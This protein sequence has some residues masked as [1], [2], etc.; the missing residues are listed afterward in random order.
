MRTNS[1]TTPVQ[2]IVRWAGLMLMLAGLLIPLRAKAAA[3][4]WTALANNA[5]G[6][7]QLMILLLDGTVLCHNGGGDAWYKLTPDSSGSYINGTWTTKASMNDTRRYMSTQVLKDGRVF[8]AGGE[9]GTGGPTA[10]VYNPIANTWTLTPAAGQPDFVDSCSML[11]PNGHVLISPVNA[12]FTRGTVIYNPT[13]NSWSNGPASL[14]S[15]NEATWVKL[16]DDSILTVDK[17]STQT[18]RYI[19]A[20]NQWIN[21]AS[22]PVVLYGAGAE[23]GAGLLLPDGRAWFIG[24]SGNTAFY[25]PSGSTNIGS[26]TIGPDLPNS[27]GQPDAPAAIMPTGNVL[28]TC[29]PIGVATNVFPTPTSYYEFDPVANTYT[30]LNAPGGGLTKNIECYRTTLLQLPDGNVLYSDWNTQ[31]YVYNPSGSAISAGRPTISSVGWH[32][33]GTLKLKG[34][35]LN[36]ISQGASYGDDLQMDSNY[37]IIRFSSGGSVYY[38]R[39]DNRSSTGVATGS[40]ILYTDFTL[41][42]TVNNSPNTA[43]SLVTVANGNPSTGITFYGPVWVDFNYSG[44]PVEVGTQTFPWNTLAEGVSDVVSGG[45]IAIKPGSKKEIMTI[46]KAMTIISVGG[47]AV[48]GK[49]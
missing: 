19:P 47:S 7:V 13:A 46:N 32:G 29:S 21:D 27:Q 15:Q 28:L 36:G 9:Y 44:F 26:W 8:V 30:R 5:P 4:T 20:L 17:A 10:E 41:P 33:D 1:Q 45:T 31:L 11:L 22:A 23:I 38:A 49:N 42:S 16:P 40:E 48:L 35:L 18:E 24:A 37:P 3:G 34:T 43:F 25:T 6:G 39:T 14:R 12:S 2:S